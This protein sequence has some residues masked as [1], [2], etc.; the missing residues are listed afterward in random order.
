MDQVSK[1]PLLDRVKTPA[2]LL[3]H[4]V[5]VAGSGAGSS[6]SILPTVFNHV[7]GTKFRIIQGYRG[8]RTRFSPSSAARSKAL[9]AYPGVRS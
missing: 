2:D 6:G 3:T 7:L 5:I 1:T 8:R 4:E 9:V